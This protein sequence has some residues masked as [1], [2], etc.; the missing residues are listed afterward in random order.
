MGLRQILLLDAAKEVFAEKGYHD[1]RVSDI[2]QRAGVAQGT[3]Y[4]YFKNKKS[5]FNVLMEQFFHLVFGTFRNEEIVDL[6][7]KEDYAGHVKAIYQDIF[8]VLKENKELTVIFL[9][10]SRSDT[11]VMDLIQSFTEKL[12]AWVANYLQIGVEQGIL[13]TKDPAILTQCLLGMIMQ[14]AFYW[15]IFLG[16]EDVEVLIEEMADFELFGILNH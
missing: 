5:I 4:L 6:K 16:R 9:R 11:E 7:T 10:E 2:V 15:F 1:T 14:N 3:F 8:Q 12:I 13:R